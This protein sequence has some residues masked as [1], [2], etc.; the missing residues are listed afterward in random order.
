M[1]V[2][3]RLDHVAIAVHDTA[4][5]LEQLCGRLGLQVVSTERLDEPP[6]QL[7]YLDCGNCYVQLVEPLDDTAEVA[8]FLRERGEGL[9][10]VC[11]GVDDIDAAVVSL[12]GATA[13]HGRGRGR[14]SAFLPEAISGVRCEVTEFRFGEDV[15]DTPGHLGAAAASAGAD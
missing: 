3:R 8:R 13:T 12:S 10:H 7:T 1:T 11:F 2:L 15:Q 9:H 14:S 5:A 4:A 6:V